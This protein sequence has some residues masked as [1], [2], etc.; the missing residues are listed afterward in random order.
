M[1][2][3]QQMEV[4]DTRDVCK[5]MDAAI[6]MMLACAS[7]QIIKH[8]RSEIVGY[9]QDFINGIDDLKS[10][11]IDVAMAEVERLE[12]DEDHAAYMAERRGMIQAFNGCLGV[13]TNV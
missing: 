13:K 5:I 3:W 7:A 8:P 11:T 1:E 9:L 10:D 4:N 2:Y 6:E 12:E